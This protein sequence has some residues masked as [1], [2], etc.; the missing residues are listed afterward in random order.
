MAKKQKKRSKG[1]SPAKQVHKNPNQ[2]LRDYRNANI[3]DTQVEDR[4]KEDMT[5]MFLYGLWK[6]FGFGRSRLQRWYRQC[7]YQSN[8]IKENW[9]TIEEIKQGMEDE[10]RWEY[11]RTDK[12]KYSHH[13]QIR[14]KTIE[15]ITILFGYACHEE[16]G[17]GKKRLLRI[18]QAMRDYAL[19][20]KKGEMSITGMLLELQDKAHVDLAHDFIGEVLNE[21]T[22]KN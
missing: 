11:E 15:D 5:A 18:R 9:V 10:V 17:F 14:I 19:A 20:L 16:F 22:T 6:E 4:T 1:K 3:T 13:N 8:H 12:A 21:T 7:V 2:I